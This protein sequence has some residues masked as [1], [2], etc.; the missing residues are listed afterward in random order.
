MF[1][2]QARINIQFPAAIQFVEQSVM[3]GV[4]N[5]WLYDQRRYFVISMQQLLISFKVIVELI[6]AAELFHL[7]VKL[8]RFKVFLKGNQVVF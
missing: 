7:Q 4:F 5:E 8:H 2:F 3:Y 1:I 6:V